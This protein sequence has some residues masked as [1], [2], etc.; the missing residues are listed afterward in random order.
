[1]N[2]RDLKP[3]VKPAPAHIEQLKHEVYTL[4][5]SFRQVSSESGL[6]IETVKS[7][8]EGNNVEMATAARLEAYLK[9]IARNEFNAARSLKRFD[10]GHMSGPKNRMF[11]AYYSIK[12]ELWHEFKFSCMH[13]DSFM[14]LDRRHQFLEIDRKQRTAKIHLMNRHKPFIDRFHV[15]MPDG[16]S[17]WRWKTFLKLKILEKGGK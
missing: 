13:H 8:I 10:K 12:Q 5:T 9:A 1:M 14:K 7:L 4:G 6:S 17:Y 16:W 3:T 11:R 2:I 15:W